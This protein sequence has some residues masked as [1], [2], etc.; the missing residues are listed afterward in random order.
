M[1]DEMLSMLPNIQD[2][3]FAIDEDGKKDISDLTNRKARSKRLAKKRRLCRYAKSNDA[4]TD[5]L[6]MP[7][8]SNLSYHILS[9]GKIDSL[10]YM[11]FF[12]DRMVLDYVMI[13]T[14]CM[15]LVDC[16]AFEAWIEIGAIKRMDAYV[17]EIFP[18]QYSDEWEVIKQIT[19]A[20]K[21]RAVSFKNHSKIM[22]MYE[23]QNEQFIVIESSANINTNP[24]L[25]QTAIHFDKEL[26]I[27]YKNFFDTIINKGFKQW[28][29][30]EISNA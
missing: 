30:F 10:S 27:F 22:L 12:A 14:W 20:T 1:D 8:D 23:K 26:F 15:N 11:A 13:S 9:N 4:L 17:G 18:S 21:G 25:E 7:V 6:S 24:R 5:I 2:G 19:G 29:P 28:K 3:L 16:K